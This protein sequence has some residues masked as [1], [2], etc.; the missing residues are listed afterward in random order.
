[1]IASAAAAISREVSRSVDIPCR[2]IVFPSRMAIGGPAASRR[3][4]FSAASS[5]SS[6]GTT[7]FRNPRS[8]A[9]S[10]SIKLPVN[11][12]SAAFPEPSRRGYS[13]VPPYPGNKSTWIYAAIKWSESEA[14][15]MSQAQARS[16]PAPT[17]DPLIAAITG[18][19]I[20]Y[21]PRITFW[22]SLNPLRS[23]SEP[24]AR[25]CVDL[26]PRRL[27][28]HRC[29]HQCKKHARNL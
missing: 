18:F 22:A 25:A 13:H 6:S 26:R 4:I 19:P 24:P 7:S 9:S 21:M 17:A 11:I 15:R 27:S 20:S 28:F 29:R 14:M 3:A 5:N 12:H 1:M 8:L 16:N 23:A 10:T 2:T